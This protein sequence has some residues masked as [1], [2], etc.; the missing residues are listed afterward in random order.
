[1][2]ASLYLVSHFSRKYYFFFLL[3]WPTLMGE[4]QLTRNSFSLLYA[5]ENVFAG[6]HKLGGRDLLVN[7]YFSQALQLKQSCIFLGA[8]PDFQ[9][10]PTALAN[11]YF[12]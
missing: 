12:F 10:S 5:D 7:P 2:G 8:T 9:P 1:M 4:E 3:D 11:S 6:V